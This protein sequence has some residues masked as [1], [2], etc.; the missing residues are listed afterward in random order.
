MRPHALLALVIALI[1][2]I[3]PLAPIAHAAQ[4]TATIQAN[5]ADQSYSFQVEP[6]V[7][8]RVSFSGLQPNSGVDNLA[9]SFRDNSTTPQEVFILYVKTNGDLVLH[10]PVAGVTT[11]QVLG[12]WQSLGSI[13]IRYW[14]DKLQVLDPYGNV[15]YE[16]SGS[17]PALASIWAHSSDTNG[18]AAFT[19][20]TITV[21]AQDD[22]AVMTQQ[23]T[24][25]L[26]SFMPLVA[27]MIGLG[28]TIAILN[29]FMR[30]ISGM[31]K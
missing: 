15:L 1:A 29:K 30:I 6:P 8:I 5:V 10:V 16:V 19:A 26:S 4:A 2:A 3:A 7:L 31:L 28:F 23:I 12:S 11:D 20:G 27:V 24:G 18:T 17:F 22:P 13:T 14:S 21:E 25:L 9:L